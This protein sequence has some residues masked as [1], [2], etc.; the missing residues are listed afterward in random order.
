MRAGGVHTM[1]ASAVTPC[2]QPAVLQMVERRHR[3]ASR[4]R[5]EMRDGTFPQIWHVQQLMAGVEL[6]YPGMGDLPL[7]SVLTPP[8]SV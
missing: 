2:K 6:A 7:D 4:C 5:R 8:S 3:A 1:A